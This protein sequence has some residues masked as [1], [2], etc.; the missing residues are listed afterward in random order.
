MEDVLADKIEEREQAELLLDL[1]ALMRL[2]EGARFL[3][4]LLQALGY[5]GPAS[6][7]PGQIAKQNLGYRLAQL[8]I[9]AGPNGAW[10][11]LRALHQHESLE[12]RPRPDESV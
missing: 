5:P 3:I 7:D 11:I 12:A 6:S 4:W 10:N 9:K 8:L 2:H 1:A